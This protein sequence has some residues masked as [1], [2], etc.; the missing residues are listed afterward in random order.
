MAKIIS[1]VVFAFF[2]MWA[3]WCITKVPAGNVGVKVYLLG[4]DKGVDVE[5]LGPGRYWIGF[6]E[7]LF[8]FPTFTQ[9]DTWTSNNGASISFQTS[10][11]LDVDAD[12]GI[13]YAIQ[14]SKAAAVFQKYRK[15]IQEIS[16]L[17]LRNM[18]KDAFVTIG[19]TKPIEAVYGEGKAEL[20]ASVEK[21]VRDQ[22]SPLGI[23][24]ER[25]YWAAQPRLP[26]T[27]VDAINAK[28]SATQKAQQRENEIQQAKAE[29]QK[30]IEEANGKAQSIELVAKAESNA[31]RMRA[32]AL[33]ENQKLVELTLA[34]RWDGKMPQVT[35]GTTPLIDLRAKP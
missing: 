12:I 19:G 24:V 29:A 1:G 35:G 26:K 30:T 5:E 31:I 10:E 27:V 18:V 11:G 16:D 20:I 13:S 6:N 34:E 33:Q 32:Q 2:L 4:S 15:G 7:D 25:V 17:Y 23:N 9:T 3:A 22:V 8:L 21:H 28:I 14:P